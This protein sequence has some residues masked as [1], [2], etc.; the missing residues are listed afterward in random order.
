ME[1][2]DVQEGHGDGA[3]PVASNADENEATSIGEIIASLV[4]ELGAD[5]A[6]MWE[7]YVNFGERGVDG[8]LAP[9][10]CA[11]IATSARDSVE[12]PLH[13][14]AAVDWLATMDASAFCS[15][16]SLSAVGRVIPRFHREGVVGS[17]PAASQ[18]RDMGTRLAFAVANNW[19]RGCC[20]SM[21]RHDIGISA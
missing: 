3:E 20:C 1:E 14:Q 17:T 13:D 4:A 8:C 21:F 12:P 15:S 16:N 9:L 2:R 18:T 10:P 7:G 19:S 6:M 5:R 11:R